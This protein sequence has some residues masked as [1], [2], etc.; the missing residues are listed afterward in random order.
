MDH[1]LI[2]E[3]AVKW[4]DKYRDLKTTEREVIE[5]FADECFAIGFEMDC[6]QSLEDAY[7]RQNLLNDYSKLDSHI[8]EIIDIKLLGSA[9]FSKWRGITHWSYS[10]SLLSE[11][12]RPWFIVA[13]SRLA[14]L[15]EPNGFCPFVLKGKAKKIRIISN[16]VGYG[17]P[18]NP[19]EEVEQQLTLCDD[20]RVWFSGYN[21]IY[22]SDGYKRG[23]QKQFKLEK[24][25]AD[26]VFYAFTRFFSGEFIDIFATDIGTWEMT[27]TNQDDEEFVFRGSLC[28]DYEIDG[29][30][31]SE[32]LRDE[33][34]IEHLFVFDGDEKPDIVNRIK[35]EY[36]HHTLIK[37]EMPISETADHA[38]W[39]YYEH[40]II[41]RTTETMRHQQKIG[42]E[43]VITREYYVKDGIADFLDNIDADSLFEYIEGNPED[44]SIDPNETKDYTITVDF[45]KRPHL[46][47][48]GTFDKRGLP[49]DWPEL[50][51]EISS[52][53]A[54]YGLGEILDP[55][56]YRKA[57]RRPSDYIFCSATFEENG[58]PYYYL[59]DEDHYKVGDLVE[60][61]SGYDGHTS[62]VRIEKIEY[63]SE[64]DAPYPIE[65]MKHIVRIYSERG[66]E[67]GNNGNTSI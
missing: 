36:H 54:F 40:L 18:P 11:E 51:E 61:T 53:M 17:P 21:F 48:T 37:T 30:D 4:L 62:I 49:E 32:L 1:I 31:L 23:R 15:T 63:F 26:T 55:L 20:G 34:G 67:N 57:R 5:N 12:N 13:L 47:L 50:S 7:P 33:L 2:H 42:S 3:F 43:C 35:V 66:D 8:E 22:E 65:K 9:I 39:A 58:K 38:I 24:E 64:E 46:I 25:K 41:D 60:V 27:I 6:G 59:A 52:F 14:L 45:K 29:T 28:A 16:N 19:D 44:V 56:N 10:E